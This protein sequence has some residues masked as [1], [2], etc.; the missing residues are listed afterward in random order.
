VNESVSHPTA[1]ADR[2]RRVLRNVAGAIAA[3]GA[4]MLL[5]FYSIRLMLDLLGVE[6]FGIWLVVLSVLQWV[7]FFDFGVG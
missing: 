4:G 6:S 1:G 3:R 2:S 7:T 5:S